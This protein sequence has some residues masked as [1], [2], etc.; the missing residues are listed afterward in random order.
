MRDDKV[1]LD[2]VTWNVKKGEHWALLGLNGSGKT[3]LIKIIT[4]YQ[5]GRK[6]EV[7]VINQRFGDTN[8]PEL[9]KKIGLVSASIDD[10]F[11]S[12]PY[13]T[14]LEIVL[15]GKYASI[16]LYEE[17]TEADIELA[18]ELLTKFRIAQLT[19]QPFQTLSQGERKKVML[20]RAWMSKPEILILDE[21]CSG[22]DI[23]AREQFLAVIQSL[24]TQPEAPTI[25]YVTHHIEEIVPAITHTLLLHSGKVVAAG[26]KH[27]TLTE[28]NIEATFQLRMQLD[29]LGDRPWVVVR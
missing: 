22:L 24:A 7:S 21:P 18:K 29:W 23:L 27:E 20:A 26:E 16:G 28:K 4:G 2:N 10:M 17:I 12:R 8:I 9:R 6:G 15:S 1:I 3:S 14:A 13:E 5:W 11:H 19:D 25:L